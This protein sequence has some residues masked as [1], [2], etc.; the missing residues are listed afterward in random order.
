[1]RA[2]LAIISLVL[3][4]VSCNQPGPQQIEQMLREAEFTRNAHN[5]QVT[6]LL[7][8]SDA[9]VRERAVVVMGRI[10]DSSRVSLLRERLQDP[11]PAVR[12][13][14]VFA[15]GQL[16][17]P[18]VEEMLVEALRT[19][20]D[21]A[22]RLKI[23]EALGKCGTEA[24]RATL[25][26]FLLS[27]DPGYQ[28]VAARSI[29]LQ[30]RRGVQVFSL[31]PPLGRLLLNSDELAVKRAAAYALSQIGV[32]DAF[33]ELNAVLVNDDAEVR[34]HAVKGMTRLCGLI[35]ADHFA[36]LRNQEGYREIYATYTSRNFR[37]GVAALLGDS[38]WYVRLAALDL[39]TILTPAVFQERVV[40]LLDDPHPAVRIHALNRLPAYNNNWLTRREMRRIYSDTSLDWRLRGEALAILATIRPA[41][42]LANVKRDLLD[43]PWPR[44]YYAIKT[45]EN[46]SDVNLGERQKAVVDDATLVLMQLAD[47]SN[48]AQTTRALEVLSV[49]R[50]A[51]DVAFF[52][53]RLKGK[54]MAAASVIATYFSQTQDPDRGQAVGALIEVY[55]AFEAPRDL[56]AMEPIIVALDSLGSRDAL[57]FLESQLQNSYPVIRQKALAALTRISG[58]SDY[59]LPPVTDAY[60]TRWDFKLLNPD[61]TYTVVFTTEHGTFTMALFPKE[62]PVNAAHFA[63]LVRGGFYKDLYIHRVVPGFVIQGGDPRGDGWGGPGYAIPCEYNELTYSR[64]MVGAPLAGKDTGGSQFF[65]TQTPQPHLDGQYTIFARIVDGMDVVDR[66]MIYDRIT[67]A[68]LTVR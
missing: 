21:R 3:I 23:I 22:V 5:P 66:T 58:R 36:T 55:D 34:Y 28:Q 49:R 57:P 35:K 43:Q 63:S 1:M 32:L 15:L 64:G 65:I 25:L 37:N 27:S 52:V 62:A 42:A 18:G 50:R 40:K 17:S 31:S 30:A 48:A 45:L 60:N 24:Y 61:S 46:I 51:P 38:S 4:F 12:R 8:H 7:S 41:E 39:V 26:D 13:A 47:G 53:E 59:Q 11:A 54:D 33:E 9:A 20:T 2:V 67:G 10:Q 44:N 56:E 29:G 16:F 14:A 68:R 19:E 6:A